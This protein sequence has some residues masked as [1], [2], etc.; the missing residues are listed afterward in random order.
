M[1]RSIH[2]KISENDIFNDLRDQNFNILS[3]NQKWNKNIGNT[4][5]GKVTKLSLFMLTFNN[6]D[7]IKRII[8]IKY[9]LRQKVTI[10]ALKKQNKMIAQ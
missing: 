6:N 9:I 3:V 7:D 2:S 8:D 4:E 1:A 5:K 10:E